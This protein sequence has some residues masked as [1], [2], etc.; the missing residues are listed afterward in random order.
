VQASVAKEANPCNGHLTLLI[1]G[2]LTLSVAVHGHQTPTGTWY[3]MILARLGRAFESDQGADGLTAPALRGWIVGLQ[4]RSRLDHRTSGSNTPG[5]Y[6]E[7]I[8]A[9]MDGPCFDLTGIDG[10]SEP[11]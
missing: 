7:V 1:F 2:H 11:L 9:S 10:P 6:L 5:E 8:A 4:A 3:R